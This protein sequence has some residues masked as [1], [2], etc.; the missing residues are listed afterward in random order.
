VTA[1]KLTNFSD[2]KTGEK[3]LV[4]INP[5]T[6][7]VARRFFFIKYFSVCMLS[8]FLLLLCTLAFYSPL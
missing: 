3:K 2:P 5:T 4:Y 1:A 8:F 6:E 7:L